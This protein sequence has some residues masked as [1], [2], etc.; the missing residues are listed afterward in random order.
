MSYK[1]IDL[2]INA[3][4]VTLK[5]KMQYELLVSTSSCRVLIVSAASRAW[6]AT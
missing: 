2:Q 4:D 1:I 6:F 5:V 3:I